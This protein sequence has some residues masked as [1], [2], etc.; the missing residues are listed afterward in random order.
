MTN[1]STPTT[2]T[3]GGFS[4]VDNSETHPLNV[5][6]LCTGYGGLDVGLARA[7]GSLGRT[8][9]VCA[10]V[11][12][13]AFAVANLVA[14]MEAGQLD[15]AP[16]WSNL[17][18]F[19]GRPFRGMVDIL[20]GGYPCQ[21]FSAA[22]VRKG[23]DDPRHLWPFIREIVRTVEPL[24]CFFENVEGHLT[25]GYGDV[26]KDLRSLGYAVETGL[27]TASEVGAPHRRKRLFILA[28]RNAGRQLQPEGRQREQ[29]RRALDGGEAVADTGRDG[30]RQNESGRV[31]EERVAAFGSGALW[32]APYGAEQ[33]RWEPPRVVDDTRRQRRQQERRGSPG[34]ETAHEGWSTQ[35]DHELA[36]S[37]QRG[38]GLA[39][40]L[41]GGRINSNRATTE[42]TRS[43]NRIS[44]Q[45]GEYEERATKPALGRDASGCAGGMA[46]AELCRA[47]DSRIDELRLAGNGCVP[48]QVAKAFIALWEKP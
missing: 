33:Y 34:D 3:D 43:K 31:S 46:Y 21:P 32:P 17:K 42:P 39:D 2:K 28:H 25:L 40:A 7:L 47:S 11:E 12:I 27:F 18:T 5:L 13:E 36:S 15:A 14:K 10:S 38:V 6:S 48:A 41:R 20:T 4:D 35:E 45:N 19:D 37:D 44:S 9:H 1:A 24:W 23:A 16:I 22:G 8:M 30:G 26:Y 29:R